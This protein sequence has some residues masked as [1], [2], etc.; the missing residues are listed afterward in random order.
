[1]IPTRSARCAATSPGSK[2]HFLGD[3]QGYSAKEVEQAREV[4]GH[5]DFGWR[6]RKRAGF[7]PEHQIAA[8]DEIA[9]A[10]PNRSMHH[11]DLLFHSLMAPAGLP[12]ALFTAVLW[13]ILFHGV[14]PAF[15]GVFVQRA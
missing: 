15:N 11:R 4:A 2:K 7:I 1:M 14:R 5:A 9:S 3:S 6:D 10:T 8:H 13:G 12:V